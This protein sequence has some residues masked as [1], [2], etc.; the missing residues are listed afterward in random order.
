[1]RESTGGGHKMQV[2]VSQINVFPIKSC[3]G[4]SVDHAV[5]TKTGFEHDRS[6]LLI[7][8]NGVAIT[9]REATVLCL[10]HPEILDDST[11]KITAPEKDELVIRKIN[12]GTTHIAMVWGDECQAVDQGEVAALWFSELI[13]KEC[14]LVTMKPDFVRPVDPDYATGMQEVGFA[15]GFPFLMISEASLADLNSKL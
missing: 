14:R 11:I 5:V 2:S 12:S 8:G 3:R 13:G 15:D 10:V 9:Q 7:G 6:W 1:M 4:S